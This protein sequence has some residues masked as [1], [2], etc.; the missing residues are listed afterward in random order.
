[1]RLYLNFGEFWVGVRSSGPTLFIQLIPC[2]GIKIAKRPRPGPVYRG[3][4]VA[5]EYS[6]YHDSMS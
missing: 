6:S 5:E 2:V 4:S 1:M 3:G